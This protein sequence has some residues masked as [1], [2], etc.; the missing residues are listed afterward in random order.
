MSAIEDTFYQQIKVSGMPLPVREIR[1]TDARKW[2]FD[3]AWVDRKIAAEIEGGTWA[4][5][6]HTRGKGF[7]DDC[8]KYNTAV[9]LGWRVYRFTS[10]M[11]TDGR[12]LCFIEGVLK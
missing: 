3:F 4:G 6:R 12:A 9:S 8:E 2:R 11:V 1:F 7:E 5:G 10:D